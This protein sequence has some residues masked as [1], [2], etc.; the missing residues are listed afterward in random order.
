[1]M[2]I[3]ITAAMKFGSGRPNKR[4]RRPPPTH[5]TSPLQYPTRRLTD[6]FFAS[7]PPPLAV[8]LHFIILY[9]MRVKLNSRRKKNQYP[10]IAH[11]YR[12]QQSAST[13]VRTLGVYQ[14]YT[15][16]KKV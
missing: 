5:T 1:M 10:H 15:R 6:I 7:T 8:A 16:A 12:R 13:A 3:N 2:I 14:N 11:T 4:A 9:Y